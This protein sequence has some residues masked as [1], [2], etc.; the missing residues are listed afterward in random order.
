MPLISHV[1]L[2][3]AFFFIDIMQVGDT[4]YNCS[5]DAF[6]HAAAMVQPA[7]RLRKAC[8][9]HD[10]LA[11]E[12]E[13]FATATRGRGLCEFWTCDRKSYILDLPTAKGEE[14]LGIIT[15]QF[16]GR[17]EGFSG[18]SGAPCSS[19]GDSGAPC[20]STGVPS[21]TATA[22][23]CYSALAALDTALQAL[24]KRA[25][26]SIVH[27]IRQV[28]GGYPSWEDPPTR[29]CKMHEWYVHAYEEWA[30][31]KQERSLKVHQPGYDIRNN[32]VRHVQLLTD[33]YPDPKV[34]WMPHTNRLGCLADMG[35][36]RA[37]LCPIGSCGVAPMV[38]IWCKE[39]PCG[40][41]GVQQLPWGSMAHGTSWGSH[42]A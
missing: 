25:W 39:G 32:N 24:A 27:P 19:A 20:S 3:R 15:S 17:F 11:D 28:M 35:S 4:T 34:P 8:V 40:L 30:I 41:H 7:T 2:S 33:P 22:T 26:A 31:A 16:Q 12:L 13:A 1:A 21:S 18:D 5:S 10:T 37:E 6:P 42:C 23:H 14:V 36:H 38:P 9:V 29:L